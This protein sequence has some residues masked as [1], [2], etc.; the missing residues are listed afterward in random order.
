M[1]SFGGL[2]VGVVGVE[3]VVIV[4]FIFYVVGLFDVVGLVWLEELFVVDV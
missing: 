3:F 2:V 4:V 1:G